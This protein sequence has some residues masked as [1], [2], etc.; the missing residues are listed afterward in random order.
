MATS[1][2]DAV[3]TQLLWDVDSDHRG[4]IITDP[5]GIR[6]TI[7]GIYIITAT[8]RWLAGAPGERYFNVIRDTNRND[9]LAH[10]GGS[11]DGAAPVTLNL[12]AVVSMEA[13]DSVLAYAY[14]KTG[15][16]LGL[17]L[18]FSGPLLAVGLI[19][20]FD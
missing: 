13:G 2:P 5:A 20:P 18:A 8:L 4:D 7:G 9:R 19:R 17:D 16:P 1:I 11:Y 15:G 6:V 12:S 10:A 14:Q 3:S